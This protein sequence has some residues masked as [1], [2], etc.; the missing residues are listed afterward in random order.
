[1]IKMMM[2]N[3]QKVLYG[4]IMVNNPYNNSLGIGDTL[5][6]M[7][8]SMC[9]WW[10]QSTFQNLKLEKLGS[11]SRCKEVASGVRPSFNGGEAQDWDKLTT[12]F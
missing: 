2:I 5:M 8:M 1:M 7:C 6:C 3:Q 12:E 9:M 11:V 4:V 10:R